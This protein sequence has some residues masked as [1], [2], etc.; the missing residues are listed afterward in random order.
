LIT[1][2]DLALKQLIAGLLQR[3]P[4]WSPKVVLGREIFQEITRSAVPVD[5]RAVHLLKSF[6][7]AID[8]YIW[9][10]YRMSHLQ[11]PCQIPWKALENQFGAG[12]RL[13]ASSPHIQ[14]RSR[15]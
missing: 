3:Q 4:T 1:G 8:I 10:T 9:L 11:R 5:L 14:A 12:L 2:G 6:P 7:L 13:Y 15:R